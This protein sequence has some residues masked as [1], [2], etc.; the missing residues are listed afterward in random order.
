MSS[1]TDTAE[2]LEYEFDPGLWER[3]QEF[4]GQWVVVTDDEVIGHGASPAEALAKAHL[5]GG[6]SPTLVYV[7]EDHGAS[8]IL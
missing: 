4:R 5:A 1:R 7:P 8:Y 2:P 3:V 6:T